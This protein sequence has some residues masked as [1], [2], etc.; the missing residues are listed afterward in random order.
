MKEYVSNGRLGS[1]L[2]DLS[3]IGSR[4]SVG[5]VGHETEVDILSDGCFSE[6]GLED[7]ET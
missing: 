4:E 1:L 6:V 3:E 5:D 2:A 7:A